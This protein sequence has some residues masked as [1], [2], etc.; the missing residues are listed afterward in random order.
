[1]WQSSAIQ[2]RLAVAKLLRFGP[3]AFSLPCP[4]AIFSQSA[5]PLI[6]RI[7]GVSDSLFEKPNVIPL[8]ASASQDMFLIGIEARSS[9]S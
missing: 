5:G 2:R 7:S 4:M 3:N 1:M 9:T 6:G 8:F